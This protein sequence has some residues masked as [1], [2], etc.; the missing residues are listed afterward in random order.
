MPNAPASAAVAP[1][2]PALQFALINTGHTEARE[3]LTYSGGSF[4][5]SFKLNYIAVLV[6]HPSGSLSSER[7][8]M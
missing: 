6:R 5:R 7:P 2:S 8:T 1:P 4:T 3:G